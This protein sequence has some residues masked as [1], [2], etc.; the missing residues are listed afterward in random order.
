MSVRK[1][2]QQIL[3]VCLDKMACRAHAFLTK[4]V[5]GST[6]KWRTTS[7]STYSTVVSEM[8]NFHLKPVAKKMMF[9]IVGT[10]VRV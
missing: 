6:P 8:L 1:R 3:T 7:I 9:D 4:D 2:R 5:R 10:P